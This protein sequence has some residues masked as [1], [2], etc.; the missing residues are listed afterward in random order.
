MTSGREFR[1]FLIP[2]H[3]LILN[4][5]QIGYLYMHLSLIPQI[6]TLKSEPAPESVHVYFC[7]CVNGQLTKG[8][9]LTILVNSDRH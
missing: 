7:N 8:C 4:L 9:F 2:C 5:Y 3:F 1:N 6:G